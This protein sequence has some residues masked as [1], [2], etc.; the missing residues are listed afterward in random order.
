MP[1]IVPKCSGSVICVEK[2]KPI[3]FITNTFVQTIQKKFIINKN[4]NLFERMKK[5]SPHDFVSYHSTYTIV[6]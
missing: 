5:K 2:K 3:V 4:G 6:D 1:S